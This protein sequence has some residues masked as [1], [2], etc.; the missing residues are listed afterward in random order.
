[1]WRRVGSQGSIAMGLNDFGN[2]ANAQGDLAAARSAY[3]SS[4]EIFRGLGHEGGAA[5][6]LCNLGDVASA[7]GDYATAR[8]LYAQSLA[9]SQTLGDKHSIAHLLESFGNLA[10]IQA[11]PERAVHLVGAAATLRKTVGAP[12]SPV[13]QTKVQHTLNLAQKSL[14]PHGF[15]SAWAEGQAL[16]QEEAMA[17]AIEAGDKL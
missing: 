11:Q 16:T 14:P 17:Y 7:Q 4:L 2:V 1:M 8:R 3:Q 12:L 5:I 13:E 10:A 9:I 15:A 6:A